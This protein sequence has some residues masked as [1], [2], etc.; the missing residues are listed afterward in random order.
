MTASHRVVLSLV[1][2]ILA[3]GC[4]SMNHSGDSASAMTAHNTQVK[5]MLTEGLRRYTN[6]LVHKDIG[7][8]QKLWADDLVFID[9]RGQLLNKEQRLANI[10]AGQTSFKQIDVS[11]QV[12]RPHGD[13][14]VAT[15]RVLISGKYSGQEGSGD[16]RVT[17][18]WENR[19]NDWQITA[20][21]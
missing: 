2:V 12:I 11:E 13:F 14:A 3:A 1:V 20:I 8:L 21:R 7:T 16:Y 10:R 6:A 4:K 18:V 15:A 19:A 5:Q 17:L 9:P